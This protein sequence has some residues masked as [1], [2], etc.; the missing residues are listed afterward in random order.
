MTA[1]ELLEVF[2]LQIPFQRIDAGDARHRGVKQAVDDIESRNFR[3][4]PGID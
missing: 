4:S 3:S 2:L 1:N